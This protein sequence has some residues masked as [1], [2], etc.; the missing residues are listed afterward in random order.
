MKIILATAFFLCAFVAFAK[1]NNFA[2][3]GEETGDLEDDLEALEIQDTSMGPPK[4][5]VDSKVSNVASVFSSYCKLFFK[6]MF[7]LLSKLSLKSSLTPW[8]E[9][10][11][12]PD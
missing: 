7:L 6:I 11:L 8:V 9:F 5:P 12:H 10:V 2:G 4:P 1:A 3:F